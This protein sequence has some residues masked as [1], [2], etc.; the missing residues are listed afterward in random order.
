MIDKIIR[1]VSVICALYALVAIWLA[2]ISDNWIKA[3]FWLLVVF[4]ILN[5]FKNGE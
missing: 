4:G 2:A 3:I 1:I 5:L